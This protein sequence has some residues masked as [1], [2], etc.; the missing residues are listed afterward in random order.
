MSLQTIEDN[1]KQPDNETLSTAKTAMVLGLISLGA[2]T[3]GDPASIV[4]GIIGLCKAQKARRLDADSHSCE[5]YITVGR[6]TSIIGL[7]MGVFLFIFYILFY[8]LLF[9]LAFFISLYENL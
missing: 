9:G 8:L 1:V 7:C 2:T 4:L 5:N 3:V 6:I